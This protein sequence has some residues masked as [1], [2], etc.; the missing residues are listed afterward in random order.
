MQH[1]AD[2]NGVVQQQQRGMH[3][4]MLDATARLIQ[5]QAEAQKKAGIAEEVGNVG[6]DVSMDERARLGGLVEAAGLRSTTDN[7]VV[8]NTVI[9]NMADE[10]NHREMID[11]MRTHSQQIGGYMHQQDV[12]AVEAAKHVADAIRNQQLSLIQISE[13]PRLRRNSDAVFRLQNKNT[14]NR[15]Q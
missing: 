14:N 10:S 11:T 3:A 8:N 4:D 15:I 6:N 13:P 1:V 9:N 7:S 2:L 5:H 12:T